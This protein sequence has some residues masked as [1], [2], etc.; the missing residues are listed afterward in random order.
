M[1]GLTSFAQSA[2][3]AL[4]GNTYLKSLTET[5]SV[6]DSQTGVRV[7]PVA[8]SES[9]TVDATVF[10]IQVLAA[11]IQES[12]VVTDSFAN[13]MIALAAIAESAA[14]SENMTRLSGKFVYITE[15][16]GVS[17]AISAAG[18]VYNVQQQESENINAFDSTG[19]IISVNVTEN[20]VSAVEAQTAQVDFNPTID[21]AITVSDV[22]AAITQL[23]AFIN[24]TAPANA[25][26][27]CNIVGYVNI[28]ESSAVADD[29]NG[30]NQI[31]VLLTENSTVSATLAP[32]FNY[33]LDVVESAGIADNITFTVDTKGVVT[34]VLLTISLTSPL[35]WEQINNDQSPN[36]V[37]IKD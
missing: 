4:G 6:S 32:V 21:E 30:G 36:W 19:N 5:A 35:V 17:E 9:A 26:Q 15:T 16:A 3:A 37:E 25:T 29:P 33:I 10:S 20:A 31:D 1:F 12:T 14:V 24:E 27:A 28:S 13:T 11:A 23:V 34:G 2:F 18:S 22:Y 7:I 8:V